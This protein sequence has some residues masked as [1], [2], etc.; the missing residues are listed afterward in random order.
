MNTIFPASPFRKSLGTKYQ[1]LSK[2]SHK[3]TNI[4]LRDRRPS[5]LGWPI[6]GSLPE[7]YPPTCLLVSILIIST[8]ESAKFL[9]SPIWLLVFSPWVFMIPFGFIPWFTSWCH[10]WRNCYFSR[11]YLTSPL[12][13]SNIPSRIFL[14]P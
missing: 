3:L 1:A 14:I 6:Q 10:D 5:T 9:L 7:P 12:S 13:S 8:Q 11:T 4:I 2:V